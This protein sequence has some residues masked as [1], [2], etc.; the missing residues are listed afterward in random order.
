MDDD[1][2][3]DII[4]NYWVN[5]KLFMNYEALYYKTFPIPVVTA[6]L[7]HPL[8]SLSELIMN[9]DVY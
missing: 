7:K 3:D 1:Y 9:C 8:H 5:V 2:D 4:I 6:I